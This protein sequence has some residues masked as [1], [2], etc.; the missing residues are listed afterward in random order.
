MSINA[1]KIILKEIHDCARKKT[2]SFYFPSL[3]TSLCLRTQ[4]K[5]KTNLK[6]LYVQGCIIAHDLKRLMENVHELNP[7]ELSEPTEPEI[8]ES[9]NKSEMEVDLIDETKEAESEEKL[10]DPKLVK[11][12]EVSKPRKKSNP[13]EPVKPSVDLEL[14]IPRPTSSNTVKKSKLPIMMDMMKFMHNQQ[15][16]YWKY[17]KVRDDSVRN[18][19]KNIS[20]NFVLKFPYYIFESW[21][22]NENAN[23]D[24]TSK[25]EDKGD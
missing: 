16:A 15:Q 9:S 25:G 13:D 24:E 8:D 12:L 10:N 5:T 1:G 11:E 19:F 20:N 17:A 18:T 22:E 6:G 14:T 2:R 4:V 7:P 3:I 23:E 21:K